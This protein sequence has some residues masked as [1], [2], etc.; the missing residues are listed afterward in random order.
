MLVVWIRVF[1][2]LA[3]SPYYRRSTTWLKTVSI[4]VCGPYLIDLV[5][6]SW[7]IS[8]LR[9]ILP[10]VTIKYWMIMKWVPM[11]WLVVMFLTDVI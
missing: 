10:Y 7:S 8:W 1:G 3:S 5:F 9:E 6:C 4:G 11:N 2:D